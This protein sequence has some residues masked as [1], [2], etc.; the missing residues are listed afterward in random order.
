M[1][2][3]VVLLLLCAV[4]ARA[5][6]VLN[7]LRFTLWH[8]AGH[9][10]IDQMD[11]PIRGPEEAIADGFALML[12]ARLLG[13]D[14]MA[15]LLSDVAEQARRDA[16][17]EVFDAWSPY[18]P[19]AQR[20]AWLICVGY[21]LSPSARP[22]ARALGLPPQKESHCLDAARRITGGWDE[23]LAAQ[24]PH[25]GSTSFRAYGYDRTLRLLQEDLLRLNRTIRLPRQVPVVVE[26]CGEDNAFYYPEEEEIVFCEE[27]LPALKAR[28]TK[29]P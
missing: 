27:M 8:E 13:P 23:I 15:Q 10:V 28:R 25:D 20:V 9:A 5:D 22:L 14:E 26:R 6:Y 12:A 21:G 17:D 4:P 2:R 1:V 11:V 29:T 7:N 16:V 19:G 18:M 3:L 24:G